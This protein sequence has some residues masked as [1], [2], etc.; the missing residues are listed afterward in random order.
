MDAAALKA[1]NAERRARRAAVLVT[2]LEGGG[3]RLVRHT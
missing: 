2:D 1:L 3:A